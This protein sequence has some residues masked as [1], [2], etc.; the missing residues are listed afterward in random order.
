MNMIICRNV[1]I[2]FDRP[3]QDR[4]IKLF[5]DSLGPGVSCAWLQG[6]PQILGLRRSVRAGAEKEKIYRKK[7]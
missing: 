1:L 2:Y 3:L 4:V 6:K 5:A 7:R